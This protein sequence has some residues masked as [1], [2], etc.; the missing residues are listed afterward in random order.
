MNALRC[1]V[2]VGLLFAA[3]PVVA[4]QPLACDVDADSDIDRVDIA[5]ITAAR[6]QAASGLLDPRDPDRDS[7][8]T[9]NDARICTQ[10]CTLSQCASPANRPPTAAAGTDQA[11]FPG[12]NVTLNGSA[13]SD[14]DGN[15][16]TY[17]W[18]LRV[19][20][21]GWMLERWTSYP[22]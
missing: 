17:R 10:R 16:L 8:I 15:A 13:S 6:T 1:Y 5:S 21:S 11:V 14:P 9:V 7:V 4:Q 12:T 18:T 19:R 3:I 22:L 2:A 20:P